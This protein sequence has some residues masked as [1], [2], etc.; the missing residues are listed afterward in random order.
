M[1]RFINVTLDRGS[2]DSADY[3][4]LEFNYTLIHFKDDEVW[5]QLHFNSPLHVS[6]G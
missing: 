4:D 2:W 1:S 5:L 3:G 6:I